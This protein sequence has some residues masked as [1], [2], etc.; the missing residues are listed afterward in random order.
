MLPDN[1]EHENVPTSVDFTRILKSCHKKMV[2]TNSG[3]NR[4]NLYHL[5]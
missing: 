3:K 1:A 2:E 5:R 4:V